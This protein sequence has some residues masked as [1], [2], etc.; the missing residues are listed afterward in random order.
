MFETNQFKRRLE[1]D[2]SRKA[3][4]VVFRKCHDHD[5]SRYGEMMDMMLSEFNTNKQKIK[6]LTDQIVANGDDESLFS[7]HSDLVSQN[8]KISCLIEAIR[9]EIYNEGTQGEAWALIRLK[10]D[11]VLGTVK[12]LGRLRMFMNE[13]D[14]FDDSYDISYW[15]RTE[16]DIFE[17]SDCDDWEYD[18]K[19]CRTYSDDYV[20]R[21]CAED[22]YNWSGYYDAY[23]HTNYSCTAL[24]RN[25]NEVTVHEDD[26][27]FEWND[28]E[29]MRVHVDYNPTPKILGGYHAS[30]YRQ[31]PIPDEWSSARSRWLGVELECE[32]R[33]DDCSR[34]EKAEQLNNLLNQGE[35]GKR[36]FFETDGSLNYG[37]EIISQPMSLP[38]HKDFWGWLNDKDAVRYMRSH[39]TTTC[40][41]HVHVSR[42]PLTQDQIAKMVLFVN[43]RSN[44]E[45]IKAIARRYAE[46]YCRIK[47]K[48]LDT[49]HLS[50]D[51]YE[52]INIT[53]DKTIE[54]RIFK[55]SLKYES[56][57]AA[58]E[59]ANAL[60]EFTA[61]N[62][63]G[64][65]DLT[66]ERFMEFI[67]DSNDCTMLVPYITN[68][69]ELA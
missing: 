13:L 11:K 61:S 65:A 12:N 26:D 66:T 45:L 9:D 50:N 30:K 25:G 23:I 36:V 1:T 29:D 64:I 37:L 68:R 69:L 15:M 55:G 33:R 34:E 58:I 42:A 51:R 48:D 40:G 39:N 43:D 52:A 3:F 2:Q 35:I 38:M 46:G 8:H 62:S 10:Y 20:C 32:V 21:E 57:M 54:F 41:L 47:E 59:F 6:T 60:T 19:S 5:S 53:G 24:D 56:V 63:V 44:E 22:H 16:Y 67:H 28:D 14:R 49:A 17:C 27:D 31:H 4:A 18:S 7:L